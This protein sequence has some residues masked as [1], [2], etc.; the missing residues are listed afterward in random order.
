M[1]QKRGQAWGF[2]L[3]IAGVIFSAGIV[4]FYFYSIN[5][6]AEGRQ[7]LE[8]LF[9]EGNVIADNLLST[10]FPKDWTKL[11]L[12]KIGLTTD[13]KIND[14]K[15]EYFNDIVAATGGY[16]QSKILL[17]TKYEYYLNFSIPMIINSGKVDFIG[18]KDQNSD[19]LVKITRF[20]VYQN[21]PVSLNIYVWK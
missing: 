18:Q 3:I 1:I 5:Y 16:E 11:T 17:N 10:G 20:T 6:P 13:G 15:L 8:S 21:Q 7:S 9:Y 14:T 19:N 4:G 12:V 2:D